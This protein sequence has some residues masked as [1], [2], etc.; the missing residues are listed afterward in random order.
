MVSV[1]SD[2]TGVSEP[3]DLGNNIFLHRP[4][5]APSPSDSAAPAPT[6]IILCTW[7]GG[8]STPRVYKYVAGYQARYPHAYILLLR[9]VFADLAFR[10][11]T[12]LRA[13]LRLAHVAIVDILQKTVAGGGRDVLL[14]VFSHGGCN[15]ALQ[16]MADPD[17]HG[18]D[19]DVTAAAVALIRARMGLVVFDSCPGDASFAHAYQAALIS[20]P[21]G[22]PLIRAL[23][24]PLVGGT[25]AMIHVLQSAGAMRSVH[26]LR[27]DLL[28][29]A[30]FGPTPARLYL[31]SRGDAVVAAT[32]VLAHAHETRRGLGCRV[33]TVGFESADHCALVLEDNEKYW[34]AVR[35]AWEAWEG[36]KVIENVNNVSEGGEPKA[37]L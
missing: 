23:G 2:T 27:R 26:Q 10:S 25:V 5:Q 35:E 20:L 4:A 12:T 29:P 13:R 1:A 21:A 11:F 31:Y 17:N 32:D 14:H 18:A 6:L 24:A 36:S 15:T 16:L 33:G 7:L 28:S 19:S 30:V 3:Q 37:M 22:R 34:R 8:A 9:T